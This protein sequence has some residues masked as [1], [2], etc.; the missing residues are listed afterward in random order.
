MT[1]STRGCPRRQPTQAPTVK[2]GES[3]EL[4]R[5]NSVEG[6]SANSR[7]TGRRN[8]FPR[9]NHQS[10]A[11]TEFTFV[12]ACRARVG[13]PRDRPGRGCSRSTSR[14]RPDEGSLAGRVR[15]VVPRRR[16]R[17]GRARDRGASAAAAPP[18]PAVTTDQSYWV[19]VDKRIVVRGHG[20]GHGHG[21]S[22]YGAYGAALPGAHPQADPRLLLPRDDRGRR[23]R[24]RSACSITADTT[25]DLV[26][27]PAPGLTLRDRG[28]GTTYPLPDIDGVKRWRLDVQDG[29]TVVGYLTDKWNRLLPEGKE[30]L[31]G[32]GEFYADGAADAVDARRLAQLPRACCARPRPA[33]GRTTVTRSTCCRWTT[34]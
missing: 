21:M 17:R 1:S 12:T 7:S 25:A 16:R 14:G 19:P 18:A 23:S 22:Q 11:T 3:R 27:S 30:T 4:H 10:L 24:A 5:C 2:S 34:T 28:D 15:P 20:F 26:V 8:Q 6:I 31:V 9:H 32:D 33:A 29:R 13:K